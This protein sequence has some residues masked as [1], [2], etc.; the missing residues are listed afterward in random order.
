MRGLFSNLTLF[1]NIQF[2][3]A[4]S[5]SETRTIATVREMPLLIQKWPSTKS[6]EAPSYD[7]PPDV[8]RVGS[9][10]AVYRW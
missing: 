9:G 3:K 10:P 4:V 1:F 6:L 7:L 2:L 5:A 8:E